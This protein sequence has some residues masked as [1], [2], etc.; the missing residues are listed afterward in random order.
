MRQLSRQRRFHPSCASHSEL[1][2]RVQANMSHRFELLGD[3]RRQRTT[4]P[5]SRR[6]KNRSNSNPSI[7]GGAN[8]QLYDEREG[9]EL[10]GPDL[11][12]ASAASR[13]SITHGRVRK[14]RLFENIGIR[15]LWTRRPQLRQSV[16]RQTSPRHPFTPSE[17]RECCKISGRSSTQRPHVGWRARHYGVRC[18]WSSRTA[19]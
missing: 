19:S 4:T 10:R 11:T 6:P 9:G 3:S 7:H 15:T 5:I 16:P 2:V 18:A 1:P 13:L 8:A 12:A 17:V 14:L